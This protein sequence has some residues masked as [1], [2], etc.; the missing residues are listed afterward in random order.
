MCLVY[1]CFSCFKEITNKD[2]CIT[3]CNHIFCLECI[4]IHFQQ[5][6]NCPLCKSK[7]IPNE[8]YRR[9]NRESFEI[10]IYGREKRK[11]KRETNNNNFNSGILGY[12]YDDNYNYNDYDYD[13]DDDE[14]PDLI[15]DDISDNIQFSYNYNYLDIPGLIE[16]THLI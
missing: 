9:N 16:I 1:N 12:V 14:I 11:N 4:F 2:K 7:L 6:N 8:K 5:E 10:L 13:Y 15:E 3:S